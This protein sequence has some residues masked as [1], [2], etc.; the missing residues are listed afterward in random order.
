MFTSKVDILFY[1]VTLARTK[2]WGCPNYR[3]ELHKVLS[4]GGGRADASRRGTQ[5]RTKLAAAA[6]RTAVGLP[7]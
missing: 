6:A 4:G 2:A 3:V 7:R 1:A 5:W